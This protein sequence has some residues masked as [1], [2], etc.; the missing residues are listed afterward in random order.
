M[1]TLV[2][3]KTQVAADMQLTEYNK[4]VNTRFQK[5]FE[6]DRY[7]VAGAGCAGQLN[8]IFDWV[9]SNFVDSEGNQVVPFLHDREE[10]SYEAAFID[11]LN[12]RVFCVEG[13]YFDIIE[14]DYPVVLGTGSAVA[15]GFMHDKPKDMPELAFKAV[16]AA[17]NYDLF[18]GSNIQ[19][20][21]VILLDGDEENEE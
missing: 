21:D 7:I 12:G 11:K 13:P 8:R 15:L 20:V 10:I 2:M 1:T 19:V 16:E 9:M 14:V 5:I 17:S 3:L 6:N 18:T 4:I